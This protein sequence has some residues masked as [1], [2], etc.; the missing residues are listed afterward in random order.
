M[1]ALTKSRV[2][3]RPKKAQ[4][5]PYAIIIYGPPGAGKGTQANLVAHHFGFIHFD[6]GRYLESL[7]YD[8]AHINDLVIK[9]ERKFFE[10]GKLMTPSWVLNVVERRA[11]KIAKAGLG[12]VFS[13]SPRTLYEVENLLPK[14]EKLYGR[15]NIL[16]FFINIPP[17][18]SIVRNSHRLLCAICG[19]TVLYLFETQKF[20]I[21]NRC[22]F[23]GGKLVRRVL[24]KTEIVKK[25]IEE[26]NIRTKPIFNEIKKRG[27]KIIDV[28]GEGLPFKVFESIKSY[29]YKHG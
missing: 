28:P 5:K 11:N 15:K 3:R 18:T 12:L 6:T 21:K 14:L 13:G 22:L 23:C 20:N 8:P 10:T 1:K 24:D 25:R 17:V 9:R 7:I 26:Y 2:F 27:Y 19:F 4:D 29:I 16:F